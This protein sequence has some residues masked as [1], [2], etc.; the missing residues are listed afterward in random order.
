MQKNQNIIE[1]K[2]VTFS[3]DSEPVLENVNLYVPQ[4]DYLAILGPNGAAKSTLIKLMVG[5]LRPQYGEICLF[6]KD[7][8][9]FNR[10]DMIGYMAQQAQDVNISF[11]ATVEEVVSSGYYEGIGRFDKSLRKKAVKAAL[12][13]LGITQ[14]STRLIGN[15][16]GGQRQKVFL[17]K[18]IVKNPEVIFLDEPTSGID[19]SYQEEFYK[20]LRELNDDDI[21]IV[22][23]THD[24]NAAFREAK[25]IACVDNKKVYSNQSSDEK[26]KM[27]VA[28][29]LGYEMV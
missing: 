4:G 9:K 26:I 6:G 7:I 12:D 3:Y 2:D 21:T 11:P 13:K 8:R 23:V 24:I 5:L 15:L 14:L 19:I 1:V 16:S 18:T 25:T 10:W 27:K 20:L 17:A 28:N 22:M 29:T